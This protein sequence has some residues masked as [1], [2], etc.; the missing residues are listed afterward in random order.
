MAGRDWRR[1]RDAYTQAWE[2]RVA[3]GDASHQLLL[4]SLVAAGLEDVASPGPV[5]DLIVELWDD[6]VEPR[7]LK[8]AMRQSLTKLAGTTLAAM[9]PPALE[10]VRLLADGEERDLSWRDPPEG[11]RM[12]SQVRHSNDLALRWFFPRAAE[13]PMAF[14]AE[15]AAGEFLA[16]KL[17]MYPGVDPTHWDVPV[18]LRPRSDT[19]AVDVMAGKVLVG[20]TEVTAKV[21]DA[22]SSEAK[23]GVFADGRI[24]RT[25]LAPEMLLL[26]CW[27]PQAALRN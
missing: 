26:N 5:R 2:R 16:D 27:V 21:W 1:L 25:A 12:L 10:V 6:A 8:K 15:P 9:V 20:S 23:R 13:V 4:D 3:S 17:M 22:L 19:R 24:S 14:T 11:H 7:L 18:W